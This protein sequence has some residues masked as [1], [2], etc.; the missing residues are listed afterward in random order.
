MKRKCVEPT[1]V[2]KKKR[3][4]DGEVLCALSGE[5]F[6]F[7]PKGKKGFIYT[8]QICTWD[9]T[10]EEINQLFHYYENMEK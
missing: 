2:C 8:V 1:R 4:I 9:R 10:T 3:K 6:S 7:Y 5:P